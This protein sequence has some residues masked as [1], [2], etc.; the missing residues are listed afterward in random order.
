MRQTK[1][2]TIHGTFAPGAAWTRAGQSQLHESIKETIR[3]RNLVWDSFE[4]SGSN[5]HSHRKAAAL[6]LTKLIV[7]DRSD[8]KKF[9][10]IAH[11]HGGNIAMMAAAVSPE[12]QERILGIICIGTPFL[13]RS[14]RSFSFHPFDFKDSMPLIFFN[15]VLASLSLL[16]FQLIIVYGAWSFDQAW[17]HYALAVSSVIFV[18]GAAMLFREKLKKKE[19]SIEDSLHAYENVACP[20]LVVRATADEAFFSLTSASCLGSTIF[21]VVGFAYLK[22]F[23]SATVGY[24]GLIFFLFV[25][26]VAVFDFWA[27][28]QWLFSSLVR[29]LTFGESIRETLMADYKCKPVPNG[30]KSLKV[31]LCKVNPLNVWL[32][33]RLVHSDLYERPD[34]ASQIAK[35]MSECSKQAARQR[36]KQ[37]SIRS[38]LSEGSK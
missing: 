32:R 31:Y 28:A 33:W 36:Q 8:Q 38:S 3:K 9:F 1:V 19:A 10:V 37:Q 29:R 18:G 13:C 16:L 25:P 5:N 15:D 24:L 17:G 2:L 34:V 7:S 11:S 23:Q 35:F 6:E 27:P 21:F 22:V 26:L 12:L 30:A 4:W 20:V 14:K